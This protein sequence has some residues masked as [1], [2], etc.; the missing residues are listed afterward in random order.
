MGRCC[1]SICSFIRFFVYAFAL[2]RFSAVV[3]DVAVQDVFEGAGL[4][5]L[6][7]AL[8][9]D[10]SRNLPDSASNAVDKAVDSVVDS[11]SLWTWAGSRYSSMVSE[12]TE[13]RLGQQ[14]AAEGVEVDLPV[15][16]IPGI[17]SS[18]LE[19]WGGHACAG[20]YFRQRFWASSLMVRKALLSRGCWLDHMALDPDTWNDPEGIRLRPASG[21]AAADYFLSDAQAFYVW[22]ALIH[23]LADVGYTELNMHLAA[24]DWRLP[25]AGNEERDAYDLRLLT[26]VELMYK[27]HKR[28]VQL[29]AHSMGALVTHRFL[30]YAVA[31]RGPEWVEEHI[32]GIVHIGGTLLG[33]PKAIGSILTGEVRNSAE[34][35]DLAR[36]LVDSMVNRT[37]VMRILR[38]YGSIPAMLPLGGN[39]VWPKLLHMVLDDE[40][41]IWFTAANGSAVHLGGRD[42]WL[43]AAD[44]RALLRNVSSDRYVELMDKYY[45]Y[46][47]ATE[48]EL[49]GGKLLDDPTSWSNP[50]RAPLPKLSSKFKVICAYGVGLDT[51]D[52]YMYQRDDNPEH[53]LC[54][55]T[56]APDCG[57]HKGDG[58]ATVPLLSLGGM[59]A[60]PWRKSLYNPGD[61]TVRNYEIKHNA[62]SYIEQFMEANVEFGRG[63]RGTADHVDIMSNYELLD[64]IVRH[65]T[66]G[67]RHEESG[68]PKPFDED[69]IVSNI[70]ELAKV[71]E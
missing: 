40:E 14:L 35:P 60:G 44:A 47:T 4:D 19:V 63:G 70:E 58:D 54:I 50:L 53:K 33:L 16:F 62:S 5:A 9:K 15:I 2:W 59:C 69:K 22:G 26:Q 29:I 25:F 13:H 28:P 23:A 41:D 46:E 24:Y 52:G 21:L 56:T 39:K 49:K 65:V 71:L 30:Q 17:I 8:V 31:E 51:E 42:V 37:T 61:I 7:G 1:N 66:K 45:T 6:I 64:A 57:V 10:S 67:G 18:G 48:E 36:I 12:L 32:A 68:T 11:D 3:I 20:K 38:T 34:L 43:G 27:V 55:N